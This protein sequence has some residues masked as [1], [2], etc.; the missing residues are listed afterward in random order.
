[1]S[2]AKLP[3]NGKSKS[4]VLKGSIDEAALCASSSSASYGV[5]GFVIGIVLVY[6]RAL[7]YQCWILRAA[8]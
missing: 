5:L 7:K 1:M 8:V 4:G 3:L 6:A 2:A